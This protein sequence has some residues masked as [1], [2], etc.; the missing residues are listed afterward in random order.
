MV[1]YRVGTLQFVTLDLPYWFD[2]VAVFA[3]L[4][5]EWFIEGAT[6]WAIEWVIGVRV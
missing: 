3:V 6:E 2:L 5:M 1:W 4:S